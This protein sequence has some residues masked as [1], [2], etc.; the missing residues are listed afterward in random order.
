MT[1]HELVYPTDPLKIALIGTGGRA[2]GHYCPLLVTI[3]HYFSLLVTID[4]YWSLSANRSR[5]SS[6][7]L[8]K[9]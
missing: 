9:I 6:L 2:Q 3:G 4:H 7:K 8:G 1:N 5:I